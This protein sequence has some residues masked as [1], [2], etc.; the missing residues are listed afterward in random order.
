MEDAG[1]AEAKPPQDVK[2][3]QEMSPPDSSLPSQDDCNSHIEAKINPVTNGKVEPSSQL[4]ETVE[5]ASDGPTLG[6]DQL[7]PADT[8]ASISADKVDKTETDQQDTVLANSK[9]GGVVD[10][11]DEQQAQDGYAIDS[12]HVHV[13][14][15]IKSSTSSPEVKESENE[16]HVVL[17][18]EHSSPEMRESKNVVHVVPSD[19]LPL[20]HAKVTEIAIEKPASS[21]PS[22]YDNQVDVNRGH[23][24]TTAPFES[25][26]EAVSKFGGIVDWKAHRIQ[27][28]E[29]RK[30]VEQELE[31]AQEEIPEYKRQS[32]IAEVAKTQVLKELDSSKRLIE[33]LKLNLERA[34]TEEHQAKQDSELAKLRVEEIEQGIAD[35]ASVAA[36][37]QLEVAKARHIAAVSE[38][39]SV[40]EEL[41]AL[42]KEYAS[43]VTEKDVAMKKA[44]EALAASKEVEKTVEELTIELIATK[45]SLES[46]HAAHLEAEEHRIGAAMAREQ[47]SLYWEKELTQAEEEL[48]RLD[49]Q[50]L[51]AKD[52]K[53]KLDTA[54]AL[55]LDLKAELAAYMESKLKEETDEGGHSNGELEESAKKTHSDIQAAV[56]SAKKELEEVK[57]NIEKA[58]A[59][60]NYLKV[61]A[62]SLKSELETE[63]SAL[64]TIR[65]REGMASVAVASLEAELDRT[66]SEIALVQMKEKEARENMVELPKQLQQAAQEADQTKSLA[67]VAREELRKAKEEAEQAKAG[68]STVESRLLAAQK[69][70]EAAKASEKLAMAAIKALE[71]SESARSTNDVDSPTGVTLSLEEYYE[72][73]K[74][75]HEAEEQANVRVAAAISQIEVAKESESRSLEKLEEVNR[76]MAARKEALK[77]ALDKAEKAK[78][79][80]L[81]VEQELRKWRSEHEQR[82]KAGEAAHGVVNPVKSPKASFE[83]KTESKNF[84]RA[85]DAVVPANYG[86]SPLA[87]SYGNSTE[88]ELSIEGK[89]VGK[90]KKKA[91]IPRV[92]M[93]LAKRKPHTTKPT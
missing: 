50:I 60:V 63:K 33:E 52:L 77:L 4:S 13:D 88:S 79:G 62:T 42:R 74:R 20:P 18:D 32:E 70:I 5:D 85:P 83:G 6:Q 73:S 19:E 34:Q 48:Q 43:L 59:D 28:V 47:D 25:V 76:Q 89:V 37:A 24:D 11:S 80:K 93:F 23:I 22:K 1:I 10:S 69:E 7:L 91:F 84:N 27:T 49:Q 31:K 56:A 9:T 35:E 15:V 58:T 75:A 16:D 29:R 45:E 8:P 30:L 2:I 39:R 51:S 44:E 86:S 78:E 46:A 55:L 87:N 14:D 68:A 61:A 67:Q 82:R 71:E 26:K 40:K 66:R 72:L 36:K 53:S 64:A 65:Q 21:D 54:T 92:L 17:S 41:E 12:A 90:K 81:G 57:L 3:A 38:L